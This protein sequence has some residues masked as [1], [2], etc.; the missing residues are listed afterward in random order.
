MAG[1]ENPQNIFAE[2]FSGETRHYRRINASAQAENAS[3]SSGRSSLL[4]QP[5]NYFS[6]QSFRIPVCFHHRILP[7]LCNSVFKGVL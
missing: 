7:T 2:S 4:L 1:H 6:F 3:L 5:G